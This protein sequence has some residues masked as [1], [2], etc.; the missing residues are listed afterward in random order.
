MAKV[1][2][3]SEWAERYGSTVNARRRERYRTDPEYRARVLAQSRERRA[4]ARAKR[5][6]QKAKESSKPGYVRDGV[7]YY[8][9]R[10]A[11]VLLEV[12]P[13]TL[14]GWEERGYIPRPKKYAH[15]AYT[16]HQIKLLRQLRDFLHEHWWAVRD[17]RVWRKLEKL[18]A[19]IHDRW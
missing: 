1:R 4:R 10:D 16:A 7:R 2:T 12:A 17:E 3:Q 13:R 5:L 6:A 14:Y 15:R 18:C 11:T 9:T 19:K 8:G